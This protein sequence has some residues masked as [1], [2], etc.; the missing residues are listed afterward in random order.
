MTTPTR[1]SYSDRDSIL[2]LFRDY[3]ILQECHR[4]LQ[5]CHFFQDSSHKK[6]LTHHV[7]DTARFKFTLRPVNTATGSNELKEIQS[8]IDTALKETQE[9]FKNIILRHVHQDGECY[10]SWR[11]P[12]AFLQILA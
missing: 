12:K 1:K 8:E 2:D 7:F 10:S 4:I 11:P 5:E 9:K 6:L 3:R